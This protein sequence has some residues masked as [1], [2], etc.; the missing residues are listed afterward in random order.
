MAKA[1]RDEASVSGAGAIGRAVHTFGRERPIV[2]AA[3]GL[4]LGAIVVGL[5]KLTP[6]RG[7][8]SGRPNRKLKRGASELKNGA[9]ALALETTDDRQNIP[10]GFGSEESVRTVA[11]NPLVIDDGAR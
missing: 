2:I 1:K 3:V 6:Q 10:E 5:F 9:S 8:M 4:A 11:E 7:Q